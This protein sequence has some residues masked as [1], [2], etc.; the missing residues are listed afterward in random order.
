MRFIL[1]LLLIAIPTLSVSQQLP[2]QRLDIE[3]FIEELI[4]IP[5]D[6]LDYTELYE[7]LLSFH[8]NPLNLNEAKPEA[9]ASMYILSDIQISALLKHIEENG[10]LLSIYEI[11]SISYFDKTTISKLIPFVKVAPKDEHLTR[12][13]TRNLFGKGNNALL[14]RYEQTLERRKGFR[15]QEATSGTSSKA[16]AGSPGRYNFRF[17]SQKLGDYRFGFSFEKDAGEALDWAPKRGNYGADS[18]NFYYQ[19]LK[20]GKLKNLTLGDYQLQFGQGLI[21][22]GGFNLGK[23]AETI[24][25]VK[26]AATGIRPHS[27]QLE[28]GFLRGIAATYEVTNN[29]HLTTFYS[30]L[31]Q[32]A[33]V[34]SDT[35]ARSVPFV[36]AIQE[37]GLHRTDNELRAKNSIA[38]QTYGGN[39]SYHSSSKA[40]QLGTT[41]IVN[42]FSLPIIR[43]NTLANKFKFQGDYNLNLGANVNY[44]W[45]NFSFFAEAARSSSGGVGIVG[46]FLSSLSKQLSLSLL[47]RSYDRDFHSLFGQA[48][49]ESS[50]N[51]INE[52]GIYLGFKYEIGKKYQVSGYFDQFKFPWVQTRINRPSEGYEYLFRGSYNPSKSVRLNAQFRQ[53]SKARN[54]NEGLNITRAGTGIKNN[55][56]LSFDHQINKRAGL[57][58]R[59]QF[60]NYELNDIKTTGFALIQDLY[61][62]FGKFKLAGR[63]ALF[64]AEDFEN[65]QYVYERDVLYSFSLPAY[66]G[67]GTRKYLLLQYKVSRNIKAWVRWANTRFNDRDTI[68]SGNQEIDGDSQND[69]KLQLQFLF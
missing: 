41:A 34:I 24:T 38:Q 44:R 23:G 5:S 40:F 33:V 66:N 3:R 1:F 18:Y 15:E 63:I 22:S 59:V 68:S 58:S 36:R 29:I 45:E 26:R 25:T 10:P 28:T 57:K 32:D 60:S 37:S 53:E 17:R 46:G 21:L 52:Q 47:V 14:I 2:G 13:I 62:H 51:N 12:S 11:Q 8:T 19:L 65:R 56:L 61:Y 42:Q 35:T 6:D 9:L 16:Y 4:A 30:R 27:S 39:I 67:V 55:Y 31:L 48:F 50:G 64:D 43:E 69:I 7:V 49:A 54:I 20:R